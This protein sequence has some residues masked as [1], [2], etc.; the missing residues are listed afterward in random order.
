MTLIELFLIVGG[1][2][3]GMILFE[4]LRS[5]WYKTEEERS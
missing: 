2:T 4:R 1:I 3:G 5:K